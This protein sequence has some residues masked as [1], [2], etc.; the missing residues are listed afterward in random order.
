MKEERILKKL[1]IGAALL[2]CGVIGVSVV[3]TLSAF[4][5]FPKGNMIAIGLMG[6]YAAMFAL[7][8]VR[9]KI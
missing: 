9:I 1:L 2:V 4:D 5:S 8:A 7:L 3:Y 6:L